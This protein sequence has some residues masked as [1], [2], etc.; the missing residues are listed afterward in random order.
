MSTLVFFT[1]VGLII[2]TILLVFAMHYASKFLTARSVSAAEAAYQA[3]VEK[4][5]AL[6]AQNEATLAVIK[7]ELAAMSTSLASVEKFL[8]Q[9]G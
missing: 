6:Q 1:T 4:S 9:G 3:L 7:A 2:G 8:K 5:V